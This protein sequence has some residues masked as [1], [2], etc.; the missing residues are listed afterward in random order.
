[1]LAKPW[2][3]L[4]VD[5]LLGLYVVAYLGVSVMLLY[6]HEYQRFVVQ[7]EGNQGQQQMVQSNGVVVINS[8]GSNQQIM[9]CMIITNN[10]LVTQIT[11]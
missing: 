11:L 7:N 2:L 6:Y 10:A 9:K 5:T 3:D 8:E 1:M 4:I